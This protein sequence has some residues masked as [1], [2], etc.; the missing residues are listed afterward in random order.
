[1]HNSKIAFPPFTLK[2]RISLTERAIPYH[3]SRM[4]KMVALVS[5]LVFA[6]VFQTNSAYAVTHDFKYQVSDSYNTTADH[7]TY[8][9]NYFDSTTGMQ[10]WTKKSSNYRQTNV[11]WTT[12]STFTVFMEASSTYLYNQFYVYGSSTHPN[13]SNGSFQNPDK[14]STFL[15][16]GRWISQYRLYTQS[17]VT[18]TNLEINTAGVGI[19]TSTQLNTRIYAVLPGVPSISVT[20]EAE[21]VSL[22]QSYGCPGCAPSLD[23][24]GSDGLGLTDSIPTLSSST[25][26]Q[27]CGITDIGGCISNAG[28]YLFAPNQ[29][30]VDKFRRLTLASSS[31]FTYVYDVPVLYTELF[32]QSTTTTLTISASTTLGVITFISPAMISNVPYAGRIR[33]IIGWIIWLF[34]V[35]TIYYIVLNMYSSEHKQA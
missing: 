30:A 3:F 16:D 22:Q 28:V 9:N 13:M 20:S 1:M 32:S 7:T 31:P 25:Q 24:I 6:F 23:W 19:G 12:G 34:V 18:L 21:L 5:V 8:Q 11:T 10:Y 27:V 4:T 26:Y 17:G 33:I 2:G 35:Q 15:V 14:I 29:T